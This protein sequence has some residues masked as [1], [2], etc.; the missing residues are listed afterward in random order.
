V[1]VVPQEGAWSIRRTV[2]S[3]WLVRLAV[4]KSESGYLEISKSGDEFRLTS[5]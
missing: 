5:R 3:C 4:E 1:W 2:Y